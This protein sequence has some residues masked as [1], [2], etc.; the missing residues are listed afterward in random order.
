MVTTTKQIHAAL[1]AGI[2]LDD[3]GDFYGSGHNEALLG[4]A[5][6]GR[7]DLVLLSAAGARYAQ[8][9]RI[10]AASARR[11]ECDHHLAALPRNSMASFCGLC[12]APGIETGDGD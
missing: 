4:R 1:D 6:Q 10:S 9:W 7:R 3:T 11:L 8:A 12:L 2:N 5:L